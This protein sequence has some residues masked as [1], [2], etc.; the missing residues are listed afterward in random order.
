MYWIPKLHKNPA[1]SRFIIASKIC[2]KKQISKSVSNV[3]KLIY[4]QIENFQKNAKFL[5]NCNKNYIN[6]KSV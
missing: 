2:F 6:K 1:R 3:F 4:A 5:S